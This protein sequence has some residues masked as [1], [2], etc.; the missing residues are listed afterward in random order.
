MFRLKLFLSGQTCLSVHFQCCFTLH[1]IILC[2]SSQK[3]YCK[4]CIKLETLKNH[5]YFQFMCLLPGCKQ[6]KRL[7]NCLRH[8]LVAF[9][10]QLP[11]TLFFNEDINQRLQHFVE[12][13]KSK[14]SCF[15]L[16][17]IIYYA[18]SE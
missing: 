6:E 2:F 3:F 5:F 7:F 4:A 15:N 1:H 12:K 17:P 14:R 9:L 13:L 16:C 8:L 11:A 10:A 18:H